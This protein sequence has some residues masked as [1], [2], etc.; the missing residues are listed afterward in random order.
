[1]SVAIVIYG[2]TRLTCEKLSD[3][4]LLEVINM[5]T[6]TIQMT[7]ILLSSILSSMRSRGICII[8]AIV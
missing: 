8:C 2:W 4:S 7:L 5:A 1:M 3:L 6:S